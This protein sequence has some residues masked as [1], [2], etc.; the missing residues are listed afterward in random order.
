EGASMR[1]LAPMASN[2]PNSHDNGAA[3]IRVGQCRRT[4]T[5]CGTAANNAISVRYSLRDSMQF[6]MKRRCPQCGSTNVRRS[7]RLDSEATAY[8]CHSPY[9]CRD[10]EQRFWVI[11]RRTLYGAVA[12]AVV[13]VTGVIVWSGLALLSRHDPPSPP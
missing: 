6:Q 7:G 11:S 5:D 9:R 13:L 12:G 8:P 1:M 4:N 2:T 10:C 3:I